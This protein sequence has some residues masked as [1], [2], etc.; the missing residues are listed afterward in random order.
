MPVTVLSTL[1]PATITSLVEAEI[2]TAQ[3]ALVNDDEIPVP[4]HATVPHRVRTSL[5]LH[6]RRV[7]GLNV[8]RQSQR[9]HQTMLEV[10]VLADHDRAVA[11]RAPAGLRER[12]RGGCDHRSSRV[13]LG[14][15]AETFGPFPAN[16]TILRSVDIHVKL[17]RYHRLPFRVSVGIID[18]NTTTERR[19][20]CL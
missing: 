11:D 7:R 12:F 5:P 19:K 13:D 3:N 8:V 1:R 20:G 4:F 18:F 14:G 10:A 15:R 6:L 2:A 16:T 9:P 17:I